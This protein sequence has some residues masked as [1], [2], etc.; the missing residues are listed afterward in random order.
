MSRATY[1]NKKVIEVKSK[2]KVLRHLKFDPVCKH[3][4]GIFSMYFHIE[5]KYSALLESY[6]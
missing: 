5:V 6:Q 3:F 1:E 4:Q 2:A